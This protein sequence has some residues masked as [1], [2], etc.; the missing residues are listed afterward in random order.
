MVRTSWLGLR[1]SCLLARGLAGKVFVR[2]RS[3][4]GDRLGHFVS[5]PD[6]QT[7]LWAQF[8]PPPPSGN[9]H[10]LNQPTHFPQCHGLIRPKMGLSLHDWAQLTP[11]RRESPTPTAWKS[12]VYLCYYNVCICW[13]TAHTNTDKCNHCTISIF[14]SVF[15]NLLLRLSSNPRRNCLEKE[16]SLFLWYGTKHTLIWQPVSQR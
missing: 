5:P 14:C 2:Y 6:W 3:T 1:A 7:E 15:G 13:V 9:R 11:Q 10:L 12:H 8:H 4:F 16:V